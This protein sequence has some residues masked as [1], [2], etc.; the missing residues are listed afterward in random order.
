M[1]N[2]D[3]LIEIVANTYMDTEYYLQENQ[4]SII[5]KAV[6]SAAWIAGLYIAVNLKTD[7]TQEFV[8]C[9]KVATKLENGATTNLCS[10]EQQENLGIQVVMA[11]QEVKEARD[12]K[13]ILGIMEIL[14][15][16]G[17]TEPR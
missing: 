7:S 12:Q 13:G 10:R 1:S 9:D 17:K 16:L 5:A 6:L 2:R 14:D 8:I 3:S 11:L 4:R 15:L